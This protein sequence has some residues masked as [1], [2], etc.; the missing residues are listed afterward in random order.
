M[1]RQ[2]GWG[3]GGGSPAAGGGTGWPQS[4]ADDWQG[5]MD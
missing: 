5:E 1:D 3:D 4:G 2:K